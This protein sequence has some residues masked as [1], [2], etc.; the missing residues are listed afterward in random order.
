V[1]IKVKKMESFGRVM[2]PKYQSAGASGFDLHAAIDRSVTLGPGNHY[3]IPTGLAF[4]IPEGY[5][6][7]IR[8]RSGLAFKHAVLTSFG[9]IDS[10]Y[11]G[12][13]KLNMF[14]H[15]RTD[16]TI[17]PGDRV[18]QAVLCPIVR[19]EFEEVS[20]LSQTDRNKNGF[21]SSGY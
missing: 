3:T 5:E 1:K 9:T 6:L 10:D 7:Q 8:P 4:E 12:E 19:V 13:V 2:M 21:G 20:D 11:R 17:K 18:A 15:G 14:N 16:Y